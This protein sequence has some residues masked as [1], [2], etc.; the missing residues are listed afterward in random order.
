[1]SLKIATDAQTHERAAR[2]LVKDLLALVG[3]VTM[4][5]DR[6]TGCVVLV[7]PGAGRR[8]AAELRA[9]LPAVLVSAS[10]LADLCGIDT[11]ETAGLRQ[12]A[13][14]LSAKVS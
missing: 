2:R 6:R 4:R 9:T 7:P 1:M 5:G 12:C 13:E 8:N 10:D 3:G 14:L 11:D